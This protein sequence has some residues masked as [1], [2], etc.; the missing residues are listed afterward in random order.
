MFPNFK[1]IRNQKPNSPVDGDYNRGILQI[2]VPELTVSSSSDAAPPQKLRVVMYGSIDAS[3]SMN[4]NAIPLNQNN[5][6]TGPRTKM[7]F[8]H[9]TLM[10]MVEYIVQH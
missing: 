3:G 10:N 2:R 5:V 4:E 6:Y 7:D 9:A 1:V 8:V